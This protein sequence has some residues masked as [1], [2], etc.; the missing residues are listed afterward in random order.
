MPPGDR[1]EFLDIE[2]VLRTTGNSLGG[3]VFDGHNTGRASA[4]RHCLCARG[5]M[6]QQFFEH[7]FRE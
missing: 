7:P 5:E 4:E 6:R 1:L 3:E 2:K